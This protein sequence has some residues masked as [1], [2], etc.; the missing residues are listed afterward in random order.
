MYIF[1]IRWNAVKQTAL[2]QRNPGF[3]SQ[4]YAWYRGELWDSFSLIPHKGSSRK[5]MRTKLERCG[6][7]D[8]CCLPKPGSLGRPCV[9]SPSK[10][11]SKHPVHRLSVPLCLDCFNRSGCWTTNYRHILVILKWYIPLVHHSRAS[12]E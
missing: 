9:P 1:L 12:S 10:A 3:V 5:I 11:P 6:T 2:P 4:R 7:N 8:I